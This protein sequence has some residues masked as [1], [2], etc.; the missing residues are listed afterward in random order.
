[1]LIVP[2]SGRDQGGSWPIA[3]RPPRQERSDGRRRRI[4][5]LLSIPIS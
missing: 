1:V 2:G 3:L 5:V 4:K